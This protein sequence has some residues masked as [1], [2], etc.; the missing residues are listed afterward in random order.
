MNMLSII[1]GVYV[2]LEWV[3]GFKALEEAKGLDP[4]GTTS[5]VGPSSN[6]SFSYFI[7]L[8]IKATCLFASC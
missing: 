8:S 3:V 2:F 1:V 5:N 7:S 4:M 6:N